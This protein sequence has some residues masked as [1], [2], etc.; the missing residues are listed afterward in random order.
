MVNS[1]EVSTG[2]A[3]EEK[4][5][6]KRPCK[7]L[8]MGLHTKYKSFSTKY[9]PFIRAWAISVQALSFCSYKTR[10]KKRYVMHTRICRNGGDY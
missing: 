2:A 6:L 3:T 5:A 10:I 1:V 9:S 8:K 4:G 7:H